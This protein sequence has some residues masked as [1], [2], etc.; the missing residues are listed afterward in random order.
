[1]SPLIAAS[2]CGV[3]VAWLFWRWQL[4]GGAVVGAMIG[5]GL[6]QWYAPVRAN[7]P[8]GLELAIQVAA[9]ITVGLSVNRETLSLARSAFPWALAAAMAF[10]LLAIGM[11]YV[12]QR[13]SGMGLSTALYGLAPGGI[14]GMIVLAQAEGAKPAIV[15]LFHLVRVL[16]TF[17]LMPLLARWLAR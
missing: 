11:A 9:G 2:V 13:F 3:V 8:G 6:Y 7:L 5:A 4:P 17:L 14:T 15:G 10:V 1:M 16:L 12:V